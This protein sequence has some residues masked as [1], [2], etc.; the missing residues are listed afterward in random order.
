MTGSDSYSKDSISLRGAGIVTVVQQKKGAR[1]NLDSLLLADFCRVNAR[2]RILEPGTGTCIISLLLAKK[3]PRSHIVAIERQPVLARLCRINI[4]ANGLE[5]RINLLEQDL[6]TVTTALRSST[7]DVI[8]A[9]PPYIRSGAGRQSPGEERSASRQERFGDLGA[10]LD[11]Q[12]LLKNKGRFVLV[13]PAERL[14]DL[15]TLLRARALEPKLLR[16]VHPAS[17]KPASLVLVEAL[18]AAGPGLR[19]LPPL[20]VHEKDDGYSS[21]LKELYGLP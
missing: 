6:R 19:V 4:A 21:E 5:D 1:F 13:F 12:R 15:M 8:V 2:D 11:L 10:W 3:N 16:V 18:K 7:F 17:D 9:N 20:F 14:T